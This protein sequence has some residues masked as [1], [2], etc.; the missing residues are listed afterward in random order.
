MFSLVPQSL[1]PILVDERDCAKQQKLILLIRVCYHSNASRVLTS[2]L[3]LVSRLST[4]GGY[5]LGGQHRDLG[6]VTQRSLVPDLLLLRPEDFPRLE[7]E[8]GWMS[9]MTGNATPSDASA[10]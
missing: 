8:V 6:R 10:F 4:F 7:V 3:P 5:L 2:L 9:D 1:N